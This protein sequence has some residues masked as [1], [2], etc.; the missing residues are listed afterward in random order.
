MG[1]WLYYNVAAGNFHTKKLCS[2]LYLIEVEFYSKNK[3]IVFLSHPLG[4]LGVT[5]IHT[6]SIAHW[7]ACGRLPVCH[8]WTV[9]A[10][11]Y[12]WDVISGN[13]SKSAFFEGGGSFW[14][15]ISDGRGR[16]P[17]TTRVIAL[18]CGI[19]IS[20]VHCLVLQQSMHV[21]DGRRDRQTEL[22]QLI[23]H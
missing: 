22:R 8:N 2:R 3:K 12:G 20:A 18:L 7:K 23:P 6:P 10:I 1:E 21:T 13:M 4:D 17:P 14:A 19:K 16:L 15:Q 11:S 5:Y 9:L